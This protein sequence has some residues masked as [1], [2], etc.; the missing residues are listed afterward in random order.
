MKLFMKLSMKLIMSALMLTSLNSFAH[1]IQDKDLLESCLKTSTLLKQVCTVP[2]E[3]AKSTRE[4]YQADRSLENLKEMLAA[5]KDLVACY[6]AFN[7]GCV[8]S[9]K[10]SLNEEFTDY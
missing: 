2:K 1:D 3:N 7:I 4:I 5:Q 8:A 9:L 6:T 10:T